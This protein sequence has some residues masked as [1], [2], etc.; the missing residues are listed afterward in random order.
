MEIIDHLANERILKII[1]RYEID[2]RFFDQFLVA[3]FNST[4]LHLI[5]KKIYFDQ[6]II[7]HT[8]GVPLF[9]ARQSEPKIMTNAASYF[10][11]YVNNHV[12]KINEEQVKKYVLGQEIPNPHTQDFKTGFILIE[13]KEKIIGSALLRRREGKDYLESQW[14]KQYR[15][16][17]F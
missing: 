15:N 8:A 12:L 9:K 2:S 14:P 6:K 11:G 3:R 10:S 5:P 4:Y 13:F 16:I 1:D 17:Q 7:V